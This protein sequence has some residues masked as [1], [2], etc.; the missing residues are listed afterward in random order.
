MKSENVSLGIKAQV[1]AMK[2]K[3]RRTAKNVFLVLILVVIIISTYFAYSYINSPSSNIEPAFAFKAAIVDQLSLTFP[4]RT[5]IEGVT[6]ILKQAGYA[7]DYYSGEKVTVDFFRNLPTHGYGIVILRVHSTATNRDMTKGP[8][9]FF[10]SERYDETIYVREQLADQLTRVAFS[11]AEMRNGT[12]YF[13]IN[14]QFITGCTNGRLNTFVI[15]MGCEGLCNPSMATAFWNEGAKVYI[16]WNGSVSASH[17]DHA[18]TCL[19]RNLI[20][21]GETIEEAVD[22]A[23]REA[24]PDPEDQ[25]QFKYYPFEAGSKIVENPK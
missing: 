11:E 13:G 8:V 17:T 19:L 21:K 22:Y 18:T 7:V 16:G 9:T 15:M 6:S 5:F 23:M 14:P 3:E 12:I 24:G 2:E 10:T 25:S 1:R 4:N 20:V